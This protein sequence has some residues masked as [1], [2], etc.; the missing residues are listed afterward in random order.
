TF[1]IRVQYPHAP[2]GRVAGWQE[3]FDQRRE[4]EPLINVAVLALG[5]LIGLG[6]PLGVFYVWYSRG[7]DP[8]VGVVPEYLS[9]LPSDLPP[10]VVG[11]L[12]DEKADLRDVLSTL[13][14]LSRRGYVVIEETQTEGFFGL[15]GRS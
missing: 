2:D 13:I 4:L 6:G 12:I 7:R 15:G 10:A 3:S 5:V 11:A 8:K 14:D 1:E 9:E